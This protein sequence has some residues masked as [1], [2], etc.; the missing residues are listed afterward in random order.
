M[1]HIERESYH[2]YQYV[3][4]I[5]NKFGNKYDVHCHWLCQLK[6]ASVCGDSRC[7][8]YW[9][10]LAV[11]CSMVGLLSLRIILHF[12]SQF[13]TVNSLNIFC[14][15]LCIDNV[16]R[17][18][19]LCWWTVSPWGYRQPSSQYVGTGMKI[20]FLFVLLKFAVT[21]CYFFYKLRNVSPPCK[22]LVPSTN[23]VILLDL[24]DHSSSSL[25]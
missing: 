5:K 15:V 4:R 6:A 19:C 12:H 13:C 1:T 10:H 22:A 11:F 9:W 23:S 24:F 7:M 17:L 3:L 16:R 25:I 20:W 2:L 18:L 21:K 8:T 14:I